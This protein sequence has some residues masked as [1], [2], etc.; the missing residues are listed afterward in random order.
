MIKAVVLLL[1]YLIKGGGSRKF[2]AGIF[3]ARGHVVQMKALVVSGMTFLVLTLV[4][5]AFSPVTALACLCLI[6]PL[7]G[8]RFLHP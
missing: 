3:F 8:I 1:L 2:A 7:E 4:G 5:K 6:F